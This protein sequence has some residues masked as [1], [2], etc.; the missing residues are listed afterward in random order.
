MDEEVKEDVKILAKAARWRIGIISQPPQSNTGSPSMG[1]GPDG[2]PKRVSLQ[3]V[4]STGRHRRPGYRSSNSYNQSPILTD[5]V[6]PSRQNSDFFQPE[7]RWGRPRVDEEDEDDQTPGHS[8]APSRQ[9]SYVYAST[10]GASTLTAGTWREGQ[11]GYVGESQRTPQAD[12]GGRGLYR[13]GS[14]ESQATPVVLE[15]RG[16]RV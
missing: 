3:R 10:A 8:M 11:G 1:S 4:V 2:P 7:S 5:G 13:T 6:Q 9:D 14:E 15:R 12:M 16:Q